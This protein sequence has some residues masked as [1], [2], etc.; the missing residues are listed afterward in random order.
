MEIYPEV[1]DTHVCVCVVLVNRKMFHMLLKL[2]NE[3]FKFMLQ[4]VT[5]ILLKVHRLV[6]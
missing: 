3:A 5:I 2:K 4:S 6:S 1:R